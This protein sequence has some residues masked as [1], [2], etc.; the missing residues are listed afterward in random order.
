VEAQQRDAA[1]AA[2]AA[3]EAQRRRLEINKRDE[4]QR[5][6]LEIEKEKARAKALELEI[7]AQRLR[8]ETNSQNQ[9]ADAHKRR[10]LVSLRDSD[11]RALRSPSADATESPQYSDSDVEPE[12]VEAPS[13]KKR[14]RDE[15][16][17]KIEET[18]KRLRRDE[19]AAKNKL[20][21]DLHNAIAKALANAP[22]VDRQI[23]ARLQEEHT[24]KQLETAEVAKLEAEAAKLEVAKVAEAEKLEVAEAAKAPHTH[25]HHIRMY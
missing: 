24:Q 19:Q 2:V 10:L 15:A 16:E 1:A 20:V 12:I 8:A 21:L 6:R 11:A 25:T 9:L 13:N 5:R 7:A 18:R 22:F 23:Q 4:A 14:R 3:A 17:D